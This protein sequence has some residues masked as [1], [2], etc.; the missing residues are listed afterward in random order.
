[1]NIS[2]E[3][4]HRVT[5]AVGAERVVNTQVIQELW[6]GYGD[7]FRAELIGGDEFSVIVKHIKLPQPKQHPRGWVSDISHQR[8]LRS[9]QVE[10]NWYQQYA[11]QAQADPAFPM[12]KCLFVEKSRD[13]ILLIL[14]DLQTLG[15]NRV[16]ERVCTKEIQTALRWLAHFHATHLYAAP[17]GLWKCGTYWHLD[18]RPDELAALNDQ[19]LKNAAAK[20]DATLKRCHYQTLVH[21]D[22]K[23]AN[24]VFSAKGDQVAAVD[25]Q[26]VGKGCGMKDVIMLLS[27]TVPSHECAQRCPKLLDDYFA[28]L[29]QAVAE[30]NAAEPQIKIDF[31]LLEQAWR[32]LYC[33]AWADFQRFIK[34]WSPGHWKVH[35]YSEKLTRQ[36]LRQIR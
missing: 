16:L 2:P 1:M 25:F 22:A 19:T 30:R 9:Y 4:Q 3:I 36:A 14:Q 24:F 5:K 18:T 12:P 34:G 23:L 7:L 6:G 35:A 20:L 32:P 8:K 28:Y 13:E 31:S 21:G 26:Y 10:V 17:D 27:S 15:F 33:V 11:N 29:Q